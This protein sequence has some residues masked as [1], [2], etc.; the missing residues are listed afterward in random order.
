MSATIESDKISNYFDGCPVLA[1]PGR[2][3]PVK[4]GYLE[5]AVQYT[6]WT[7]AENSQYALHGQYSEG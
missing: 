1:V 7:I 4:V 6:G 3:F 5:D 2:T